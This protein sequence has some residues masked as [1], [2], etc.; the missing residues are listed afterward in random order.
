MKWN[1]VL[2]KR[3]VLP[4]H[5]EFQTGAPD[6]VRI[7][8]T[9]TLFNASA[10]HVWVTII[11]GSSHWP[12]FLFDADQSWYFTVY[13]STSRTTRWWVTSDRSETSMWMNLKTV[14]EQKITWIHSEQWIVCVL[15]KARDQSNDADKRKEVKTDSE[16]N[17]FLLDFKWDA[18]SGAFLLLQS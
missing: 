4:L 10:L 18:A 16:V 2:Q 13:R 11:S 14:C 1:W 15:D 12:N 5:F 7:K 17:V 9:L 8:V 6:T 3:R